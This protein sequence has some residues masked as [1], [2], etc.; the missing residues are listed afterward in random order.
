MVLVK[1]VPVR[2]PEEAV[3]GVVMDGL[4]KRADMLRALNPVIVVNPHEPGCLDE[5]ERVVPCGGKVVTPV[6]RRHLYRGETSLLAHLA[7]RAH[8]GTTLYSKPRVN[9]DDLVE[10]GGPGTLKAKS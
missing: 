10:P 1:G 2:K 7:F 8:H 5:R 9:Y 6:K 4:N 3:L